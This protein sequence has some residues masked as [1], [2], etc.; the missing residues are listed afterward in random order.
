MPKNRNQKQNNTDP[1][2]IYLIKAILLGLCATLY[3]A[4]I[5][6]FGGSKL[7]EVLGYIFIMFAS[8]YL[9]RYLNN[10]KK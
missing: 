8:M 5:E 7:L 2:R 6:L 1:N 4:E 10:R 3:F 9:F